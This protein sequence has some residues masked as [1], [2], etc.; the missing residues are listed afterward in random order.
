MF[1]SKYLNIRRVRRGKRVSTCEMKVKKHIVAKPC[2][3][4][5]HN[6]TQ[7]S[8]QLLRAQAHWWSFPRLHRPTL[9]Y[10]PER[11]PSPAYPLLPTNPPYSPFPRYCP[12]SPPALKSIFGTYCT[13]SKICKKSSFIL[14]KSTSRVV[15]VISP[16]PSVTPSMPGPK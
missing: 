8:N 11:L 6:R 1:Y 2:V 5:S 9:P 10:S 13:C 4:I 7:M 15:K 16:G 12:S 14:L 3:H